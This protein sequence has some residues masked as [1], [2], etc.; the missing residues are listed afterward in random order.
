MAVSNQVTPP[1]LKDAPGSFA[2]QNWYNS[3]YQYTNGSVGSIPWA[4]VSKTGS[5]L[6]DLASRAHSQLTGV[7]GSGVYHLTVDEQA[8]VSGILSKA[9]DPTTTDIP[10]SGWAIYK[11]TSTGLVKLWANDGGTLKSVLLT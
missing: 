6:S 3:V 8:K 1:P 2:W 7:L 9:G 10:A 4:A 11:N 5:A